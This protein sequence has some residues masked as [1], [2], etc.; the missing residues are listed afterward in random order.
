MDF[1]EKLFNLIMPWNLTKCI[2][3]VNHH[4]LL[5][6]IEKEEVRSN[7]SWMSLNLQA[8]DESH[9]GCRTTTYLC[10]LSPGDH[11]LVPY[12]YD[13]HVKPPVSKSFCIRI[14]MNVDVACR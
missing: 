1:D 9:I 7:R 13:N 10:K 12:F 14:F 5:F 2:V 3:V 8:A 4:T 6:Q 11:L